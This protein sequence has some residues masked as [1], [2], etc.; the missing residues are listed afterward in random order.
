MQGHKLIY[1]NNIF[2]EIEIVKNLQTEIFGRKEIHI[3]NETDSTNIQAFRIAEGG[4]AEGS[5]I[6][7][8]SQTGG[9]GRLGRKWISPSGK[10]LY[11]S[12]IIRPQIP[13]INAPRLTIVTAAALSETLDSIGVSAHKIKWPNDMLFD[14]KK[15]S[16]IL[17]EMKGDGSTINFIIIGVGVN[18]N[19]T[20]DNYPDEIKDSVIS[21]KEITGSEV[22]RIKFL[23]SFLLHFEKN[24]L[25]FLQGRFP[26][27]IDKWIIKSEIINQKINVTDYNNT[28]TGIVTGIT[29][30]GN[31]IL[32]TGN[33][34]C[35]V[36]SGDINFLE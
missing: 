20:A 33:G 11:L 32:K 21:L 14:G 5:I 29:P 27:I 3:F 1:H 30:D 25:D 16:G 24:Y 36:S 34:T 7:A 8:E 4:A 19:S 23:N 9:K 15:L 17:A 35:Y 12:M 2:S 31:L 10:N 28:F 6:I 26:E 13:V 22:D 18:I